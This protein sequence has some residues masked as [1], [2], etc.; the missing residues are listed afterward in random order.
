MNILLISSL[1][2]TT[3]DPAG[4]GVTSALHSFV[5]CWNRHQQANVLV[6]CPVYFYVREWF[7]RRQSQRP[8]KSFKSK[9]ISLDNV[10][11][12]VF[13]VFKIPRIAYF[14]YPLY[15]YLDKYL[16][17][18]DFKVDVVVAHYDKSLYIGYRYSRKRQLP[19]AI[20]LHITPD[21]VE[22]D[23]AAFTKRCGGVLEAASVIAC[24]SQY[25]YD[26]IRKWF[27]RYEEK[28]FIAFSGIEE[29]FIDTPENA[30]ARMRQWKTAGNGAGVSIISV[31]SLIERKKIDANLR[32][33]A[34]LKDK[35]QWTYTIIGEG[36]ERAHLEAL[37]AQLGI[38]ARVRFM[39]GVPRSQVIEALKRSHIFVMVS[40][41]ET[42]GLVYLEAMAAGN[43]VIGGRGE[44]IDGVIQ[45]EKNGFLSLPGDVELL[46]HTLET[47]IFQLSVE[48]LAD[49]LKNAYRTIGQYTEENAARNYWRQL[50]KIANIKK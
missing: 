24:R 3:G 13:P 45:H 49:I 32:A 43:I 50:N 12:I 22:D 44:G 47:I 46:K 25:I 14:Y 38:R 16:K 18:V 6:V 19:L 31:C 35:F 1:Y 7:R 27:P 41:L 4:E 42:F 21:L 10:S 5:K 9:I 11:V 40:Y 34:L 37:T 26:K 29:D 48:R 2:P 28:S 8:G 39:G 15:R 17:A 33:L 36:E 23:P 30:A 20:G